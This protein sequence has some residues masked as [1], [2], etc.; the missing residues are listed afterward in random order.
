[1]SEI[2]RLRVEIAKQRAA[3]SV[4]QQ[5]SLPEPERPVPPVPEVIKR[6]RV[7]DP[8]TR[9]WRIAEFRDQDVFTE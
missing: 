1:V 6:V 4:R 7:W 5:L 9:A 3:Q 8:I 2:S